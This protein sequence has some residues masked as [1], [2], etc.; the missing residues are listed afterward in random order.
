M[1]HEMIYDQVVI[2]ITRRCNMFCQHCLRGPAQ[3]FDIEDETLSKFFSQVKKISVLTITG[4]EPSMRPDRIRAVVSY[5]QQNN[6][7]IED[8]FVV[9][10]GKKITREFLDALEELYDYCGSNERSWVTVSHDDYH[11]HVSNNNKKRL[12]NWW[13]NLSSESSTWEHNAEQMKKQLNTN[14]ILNMG[15]A[16]GLGTTDVV[17]HGY[18]D[19]IEQ[20]FVEEIVYLNVNGNIM[21]HCDLS[22]EVQDDGEVTVCT[23]DDNI[24]G[25][26][27]NYNKRKFAEDM[28]V[29]MSLCG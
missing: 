5:A 20:C 6:V 7:E 4:G 1:E 8:F 22:Y 26:I 17:I 10:N 9:T 12:Y 16:R 15:N 13:Y 24:L 19:V 3:R 29:K 18:S 11:D 27:T 2:E 23:V 14:F 25:A 28:H 21:P